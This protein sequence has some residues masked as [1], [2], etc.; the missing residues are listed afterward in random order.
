MR[1][2]AEAR[3]GSLVLYVGADEADTSGATATSVVEI[4]PIGGRLVLFDSRSILHEVMPHEHQGVERLAMT[5][6]IG[7]AHTVRG[8]ARHCQAWWLPSAGLVGITK[9]FSLFE[10][11]FFL[12][13]G[14]TP[15]M[16][17]THTLR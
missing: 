17:K 12:G 6:W 10:S 16:G 8:F 2:A 13:M 14:K 11:L 1:S 5:V 4:L 9:M 3:G 7:G 15:G